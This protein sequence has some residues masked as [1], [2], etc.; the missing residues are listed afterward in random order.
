MNKKSYLPLENMLSM[1][2]MCPFF[3]TQSL[4]RN[5]SNFKAK[6]SKKV[7]SF[8]RQGLAEA[9][10]PSPCSLTPSHSGTFC[11]NSFSDF[12]IIQDIVCF[13][14]L[15]C[16]DANFKKK[17]IILLCFT[18]YLRLSSN[19]NKHNLNLVPLYCASH[20]NWVKV[21]MRFYTLYNV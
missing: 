8:D 5:F 2:T 9:M 10:L 15:S 20:Q 3:F 16:L 7:L 21:I 14:Q 19:Q 17:Y 12:K 6:L 11:P 13:F 4:L 1:Q 18:H